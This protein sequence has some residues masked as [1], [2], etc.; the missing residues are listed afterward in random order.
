[1]LVKL[2]ANFDVSHVHALYSQI[3][4]TISG[5]LVLYMNIIRDIH[6]CNTTFVHQ[7]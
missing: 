3:I 6:I 2:N 5:Y 4:C 7:L 1:M